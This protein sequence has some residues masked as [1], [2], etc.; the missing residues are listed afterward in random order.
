MYLGSFQLGQ[1]VTYRVHSRTAAG[2]PAAP[3]AAP[4]ARVLAQDG[5]PVRS[6]LKVPSRDYPRTVGLFEGRLQLDEDFDVG[7]HSVVVTWAVSGVAKAQDF[8]FTVLPGGNGSGQVTSLYSHPR[9]NA[10]YV[11][12]GRDSGRIYK[13]KNP[14]V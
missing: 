10:N 9:P 12:Q 4:L 3:D 14:R 13:G 2:V 6:G 11:V 8:Y 7:L 5:D 1:E